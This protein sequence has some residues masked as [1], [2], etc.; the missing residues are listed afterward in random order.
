MRNV[1]TISENYMRG[2]TKKGPE[3]D[4]DHNAAVVPSRQAGADQ[5]GQEVGRRWA[6]VPADP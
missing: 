3:E 2:K 4:T 6:V 5:A 1:K